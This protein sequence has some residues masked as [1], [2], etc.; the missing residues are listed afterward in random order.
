MVTSS[1]QLK[2]SPDEIHVARLPSTLAGR[3]I[4]CVSKSSF[5]LNASLGDGK[6]QVRIESARASA[7][8]D[9]M[10]AMQIRTR[11]T[12]ISLQSHELE[13]DRA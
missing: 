6:G 9:M 8:A 5:I 4:R 10:T 3:P 13:I 2:M 7:V 11:F 1:V 12:V